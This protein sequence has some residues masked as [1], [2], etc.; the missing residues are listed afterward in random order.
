MSPGARKSLLI[1]GAIMLA[2]PFV[3]GLLRR[4]AIVLPRLAM[5]VLVMLAGALAIVGAVIA[6]RGS[7]SSEERR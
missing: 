7:R 5:I 6:F 4:N 3:A 2:V 1:G